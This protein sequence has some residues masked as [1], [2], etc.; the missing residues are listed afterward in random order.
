MVSRE[1]MNMKVVD[2]IF[3]L[4][5]LNK[6]VSNESQQTIDKLIQEKNSFSLQ[7]QDEIKKRFEAERRS[8]TFLKKLRQYEDLR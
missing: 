1:D 8:L 3:E 2:Y 5:K 4:K 6:I 7:V